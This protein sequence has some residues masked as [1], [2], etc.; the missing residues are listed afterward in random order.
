M[1]VNCKFQIIISLIHATK[2]YN[3]RRLLSSESSV[4][5]KFTDGDTITLTNLNLVKVAEGNLESHLSIE[6]F[7]KEKLCYAKY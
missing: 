1:F 6:W 7:D 5:C 3:R 4:P 2:M